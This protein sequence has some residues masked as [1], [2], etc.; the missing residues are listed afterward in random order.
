MAEEAGRFDFAAVARG[1]RDKLIRRH[2]HVFA[3][4]QALDGGRNCIV[5]W[6]AQKARERAA[7]GVH[8]RAV[9]CAAGAAGAGAR[10]QARPARRAA[11][12]STGRRPRGVRAK[13][14][15]ELAEIDAAIGGRHSREQVAEE[16]GDLLFTIA[17]WARHLEVD[18]EDA[19]R[20]AALK[21]ERRFECMERAARAR[22]AGA[23]AT[24]AGAVG[25]ALA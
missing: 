10:R 2:P 9:G 3:E 25:A 8:G 11:S 24:D 12:A 21:F 15:E 20:R 1:I 7:A 17:N 6:E 18:A 14:D 16:I 5:S 4:R 13:I 22:R 19:L 23:R